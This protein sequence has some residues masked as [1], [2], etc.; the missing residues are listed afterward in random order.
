MRPKS[1]KK[2]LKVPD[3]SATSVNMIGRGH[4]RQWSRRRKQ[5]VNPSF[6]SPDSDYSPSLGQILIEQ[7]GAFQGTRSRIAILFNYDHPSS[8]RGAISPEP[9]TLL[10]QW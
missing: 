6:S 7:E 2:V 1:Q 8:S 9:L 5:G 4:Y 10:F 3:F